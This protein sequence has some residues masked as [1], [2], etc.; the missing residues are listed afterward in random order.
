MQDIHHN[1]M[2]MKAERKQNM[3]EEHEKKTKHE[4]KKEEERL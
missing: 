2:K 3:A 4:K 1:I